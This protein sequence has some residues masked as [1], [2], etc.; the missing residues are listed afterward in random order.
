MIM[1]GHSYPRQDDPRYMVQPLLTLLA[2]RSSPRSPADTAE[3]RPLCWCPT[4]MLRFRPR[5]ERISTPFQTHL[6]D[7]ASPRK[8][9]GT[10]RRILSLM[11]FHSLA[12]SRSA[13][14]HLRV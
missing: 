4:R 2:P 1:M 3:G 11:L 12:F 9:E 10:F 13:A 8:A 5:E 7:V 6:D 14:L